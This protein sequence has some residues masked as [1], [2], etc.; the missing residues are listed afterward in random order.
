M[1]CREG[2]DKQP[3]IQKRKI[4]TLQKND[5]L[6]ELKP[7]PKQTKPE[8][9]DSGISKAVLKAS[10]KRPFK[11]GS[12]EQL[13]RKGNVEIVDL[14]DEKPLAEPAKLRRLHEKTT[15]PKEEPYFLHSGPKSYSF[16]SFTAVNKP[17][18]VIDGTDLDDAPPQE[19]IQKKKKT[20][21]PSESIVTR[22]LPAV[23]EEP[24]FEEGW[25]DSESESEDYLEFGIG[26]LPPPEDLPRKKPRSDLT[27]DKENTFK[28]TT[29]GQQEENKPEK[30]HD[31]WFNLEEDDSQ[32]FWGK[33]DEGLA[34]RSDSL[35]EIPGFTDCHIVTVPIEQVEIDTVPLEK[36]DRLSV[37]QKDEVEEEHEQGHEHDHEDI[38]GL[39]DF[40]GDC[41]EVV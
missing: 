38:S 28:K 40:L 35:P 23:A 5:E 29:P 17:Q 22:K 27:S 26:G 2:L 10:A 32:E 14:T 9:A 41:V 3:K 16:P 36:R 39:L 6:A 21:H 1:C 19:H 30:N 4:S 25:S 34:C 8:N 13:L 7:Q 37:S 15:L 24:L 18:R 11:T 31:F 33:E 12:L 20:V